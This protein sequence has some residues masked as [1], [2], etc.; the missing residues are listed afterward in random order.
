MSD[1]TDDMECLEWQADEYIC[2]IGEREASW[3]SGYHKTSDD[4]EI[5][6]SKMTVSHLQNAIKYFQDDHDTSALEKELKSR[7]IKK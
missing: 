1:T 5:K 2:A 6:L 7:T 4:R 3:E